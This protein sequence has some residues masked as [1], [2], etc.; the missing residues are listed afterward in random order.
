MNR[1]HLLGS[2]ATGAFFPFGFPAQSVERKRLGLTIWS[3]NVRWGRRNRE[4]APE[5]HWKSALDVLDKCAELGAGC[6]QIGVRGWT[7]DFAGKLRD[8]RENLGVKLEGQISLPRKPGDIERFERELMAAK[9]AGATVLRTVCLGGRRY[10]TFDSLEEWKGFVADSTRALESVESMLGKH[11]MRLAVENHKDWRIT[12]QLDLLGRLE[13]EWIGVNFDFGNNYALLEDPHLVAEGLAP[14]MMTTHIK[15]MSLAEYGDGLLL[16]E[17]PLGEGVLDLRSMMDV[18][19]A[20]QP[21]IQFNLEMITRDPLRVPVLNEKYW[22]TMPG[23]PGVELATCMA[24]ARRGDRA[25]LPRTEGMMDRE[26]VA[27]EEAQVRQSFEYARKNLG[28]V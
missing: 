8:T 12:E 18:C 2:A 1:R 16:S 4:G 14:Y 23:V 20:K 28:L 3:Y 21:G 7:E 5:P 11:R 13:S 27:L 9:E 22:A 10:E 24:L 26:L 6:L 17:V 25:E 19:E 15:D